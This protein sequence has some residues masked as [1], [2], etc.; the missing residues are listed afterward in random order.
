MEER[1]NLGIPSGNAD[2]PKNR[3]EFREEPSRSNSI[4]IPFFVAAW[5]ALFKQFLAEEKEHTKPEPKLEPITSLPSQNTDALPESADRSVHRGAGSV[6]LAK[7]IDL[8]R[9]PDNEGLGSSAF[10][11]SNFQFLRTPAPKLRTS[12]DR[13]DF[14]PGPAKASNDNH[15]PSSSTGGGGGG[16]GGGGSDGKSEGKGGSGGGGKPAPSNRRPTVSGP[17]YLR[18]GL[19][20][21]SIVITMA[22]LLKGA[23][24]PDGDRLAVQSLATES[25]TLEQLGLD[26]WLYTPARDEAGPV[27]LHYKITD[28]E[29][30]VSQTAHSEFLARNGDDISGTDGD[31]VLIGT[32]LNDVIDARGGNDVVYGRESDDAIRGGDGDDRLIGGDGN[33]VI[34]G[35]SGND[36]IFGGAGNDTLFGEDGND[37]L[38]GEDGNDLISGGPGDDVIDGGS[39]RN[40]VDAGSGDDVVLLSCSD[41]SDIIIG[42]EGNDTIDLHDIVFDS[43][44]NLPDGLI[45]IGGVDRAQIFEIENIRGGHGRDHLIADGQVNIM[46]GGQGHDTFTFGTL[47]SVANNGGPRDH[48]LDFS[49]GDRLD[50]SGLGHELDEF[51]GRKIFLA[52]ASSASFAEIGAVTYHHEIVEDQEITV[53]A[54]NLDSDPEPE[55]EIVL[56]GHHDLTQA[57][58][59]FEANAHNNNIQHPA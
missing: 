31:D 13:D 59:I 1:L 28:G 42:G 49:S 46:V 56:D 51:A 47:A 2:A 53:V 30:T 37:V 11:P 58:F 43:T 34:W 41:G 12:I 24:D 54:G 32:P 39:G 26:R 20:N 44:V 5:A 4:V 45:I 21:Q 48:I 8:V 3:F 14:G 22:E 23:S 15:Q 55:F 9:I 18:N 17:V 6:D 16:S 29:A 10:E 52:E 36:V 38:F 19:V 50:L 25:G 33:D 7:I 40:I 27:A 57:D 35:G